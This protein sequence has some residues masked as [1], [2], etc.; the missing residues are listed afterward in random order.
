MWRLSF[1][2]DSRHF[3]LEIGIWQNSKHKSR[4]LAENLL[5]QTPALGLHLGVLQSS[6]YHLLEALQGSPDPDWVIEVLQA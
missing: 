3:F 1:L 2:F 4:Y 5:V 6:G